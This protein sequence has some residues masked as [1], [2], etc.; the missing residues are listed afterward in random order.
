[1]SHPSLHQ[2]Q[3]RLGET[4]SCDERNWVESHVNGCDTCLEQLEVLQR[5]RPAELRLLADL[6]L[7]PPPETRPAPVADCPP[8]AEGSVAGGTA[9][10]T[11]AGH[12]LLVRVAVG[13]MGEVYKARHQ[14]TGRI[15]ALKT[16]VASGGGP[17]A[18]RGHECLARFRTE[19]EAVSRLQHPHIVSLYE[20]GE[21]DGRLYFTMEWVEGSNLAVKLRGTP[22]PERSAAA[23]VRVLAAAMHYAHQR[24]IVHRDLKPA[25]ILLAPAGAAATPWTPGQPLP[26]VEQEWV[27]KIADFGVAKLLDR[28]GALTQPVQAVGT[29]EYM[30]PEQTAAGGSTR[31][32]GPAADVYALGVILYELLTG[33]PPFKAAGRWRPWSRCGPR[34]R[35]RR[36]AC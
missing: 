33:R 1:M 25:N 36:V 35:C 18:P 2:L 20:V 19:A 4:L 30:A 24:H 5:P 22:Q 16:V 8:S 6:L 32:V 12:E 15:V 13:G 14:R 34:S 26:R 28:G 7:H 3:R 21:Q 11:F 23:W 27:P 10:P 31:E 9:W 17:E 29:P